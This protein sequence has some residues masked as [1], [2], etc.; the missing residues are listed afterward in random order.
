MEEK[1]SYG[2]K[3]CLKNRKEKEGLVVI[4]CD[5]EVSAVASLESVLDQDLSSIFTTD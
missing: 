1:S 5:K 3:A 2:L 4:F